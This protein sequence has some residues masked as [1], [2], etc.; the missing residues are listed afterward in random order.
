MDSENVTIVKVGPDK[1]PIAEIAR[2][3]NGEPK[4]CIHR[5]VRLPVGVANGKVNAFVQC[6]DCG[7]H[8]TKVKEGVL[9][10]GKGFYFRFR[11]RHFLKGVLPDKHPV[12][13]SG[14]DFV[15]K[16]QDGKPINIKKRR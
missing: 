3:E 13:N 1:K 8:L 9:K 16:V 15:V 5:H 2:T 4:E 10:K 14:L 7:K 6:A 12:L 11:T